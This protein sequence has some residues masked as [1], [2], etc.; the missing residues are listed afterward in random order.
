MHDDMYGSFS[1][2][3]RDSFLGSIAVVV[4]AVDLL[5]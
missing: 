1:S 5:M 3:R 4:V 2:M